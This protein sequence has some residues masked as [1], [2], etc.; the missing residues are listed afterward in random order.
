MRE[1]KWHA[2]GIFCEGEANKM[3]RYFNYYAEVAADSV[4]TEER[5]LR[6]LR[7]LKE[8]LADLRMWGRDTHAML[9]YVQ[10]ASISELGRCPVCLWSQPGHKNGCRMAE[11]I[12]RGQELALDRAA[13]PP[14]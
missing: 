1:S 7:L 10:W 3:S 6:E 11:L 8:E 13:E 2:L 12:Y 4:R 9:R 14:E 5:L